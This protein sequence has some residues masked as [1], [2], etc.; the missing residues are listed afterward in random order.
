MMEIL[1]ERYFQP[2]P[3]FVTTSLKL[4][5]QV[6][7]DHL[8]IQGVLGSVNAF[9]KPLHKKMLKY[10]V[11]EWKSAGVDIRFA[12]KSLEPESAKGKNLVFIV[13]N[14]ETV[15]GV[16]VSHQYDFVNR[17]ALYKVGKAPAPTGPKNLL[18]LAD[19]KVVTIGT[20]LCAG[21]FTHGAGACQYALLLP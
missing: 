12:S 3:V 7:G 15:N 17:W 8:L 16:T 1:P 5:Q 19:F 21:K 14:P 18:A 20:K 2:G 10:A 4:F 13:G 6:A 11:R 9:D